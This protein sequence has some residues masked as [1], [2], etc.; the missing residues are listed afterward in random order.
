M[1][2]VAHKESRLGR[3]K[4]NEDRIAY[5]YS[6]DAL[7]MVVADGMGGHLRGEVAA[8]IAVQIITG[9]FQREATP[10]LEDPFHFLSASFESAHRAILDYTAGDG[11]DSPRTTCVAC[12]VQDSIA[13]WAHAG[14]SRLYVIRGGRLLAQTRDHS[15]VQMLL[16]EGLITEEEATRHPDRNRIFSCL[17]GSQPPQ[18]DFS[19]KTPLHEGDV[20]VLCTDGFWSPLGNGRL[21]EGLSSAHVTQA[22]PQL[23]DEAEAIAGGSCDNLSAVAIGW[24]DDY[25]D[26]S[27][28][29][30]ETQTLP[31]DAHTIQMDDF[32]QNRPPEAE[33]TD[34]DIER[35]IA[36]IRT[37]IRKY[38]K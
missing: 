4:D 22:V 18:V 33:L 13:Y 38:S 9:A 19:R 12:I 14:D 29:P 27:T 36:E 17:G 35:A 20:V 26:D 34:D 23:M 31:L 37:T 28:G 21:V 5:C 15:R 7:L 25:A 8:Q 16:D 2:F 1:R 30:I 3:R 10:R 24:E 6:R 32:R 11:E